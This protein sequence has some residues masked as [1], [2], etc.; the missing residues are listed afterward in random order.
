MKKITLTIAIIL[1]VIIG[2]G[3]YLGITDKINPIEKLYEIFQEEEKEPDG[4][5]I[6]EVVKEPIA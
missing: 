1:L 2:G 6:R 5:I 3:I 4:I